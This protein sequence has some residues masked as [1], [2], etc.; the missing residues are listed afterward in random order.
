MYKYIAPTHYISIEHGF[1]DEKYFRIYTCE[2]YHICRASRQSN[3]TYPFNLSELYE[4]RGLKNKKSKHFST[5]HLSIFWFSQ[6]GT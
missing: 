1:I 4:T 2:Y 3:N 5:T 6:T